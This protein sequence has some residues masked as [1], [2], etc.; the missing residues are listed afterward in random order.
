VNGED[1]KRVANC[2]H[3]ADDFDG[4]LTKDAR[5][6]FNDQSLGSVDKATR[7][8][9]RDK[10]FDGAGDKFDEGRFTVLDALPE[11]PD[12]R[13]HRGGDMRDGQDHHR[14]AVCDKLRA[15]VEAEPADPEHGRTD[16]YKAGVMGWG[17]LVS[18]SSEEDGNHERDQACG[19]VDDDA[20]YEV[21]RTCFAEAASVREDAAAPD[22]F[23]DRRGTA[24]SKE[25]KEWKR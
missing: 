8:S 16:H 23:D 22:P 25:K 11:C 20:A 3:V 2:M 21:A 14:A 17:G 24:A 12:K 15:S 7:S 18:P 1:I 9:D 4:F 10:A 5:D 6:C 19:L 13:G